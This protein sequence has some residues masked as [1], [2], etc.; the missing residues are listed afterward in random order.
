VW[1]RGVWHQW[2]VAC[3]CGE[4]SQHGVIGV[5]CGRQRAAACNGVMTSA[6]MARGGMWHQR[7]ACGQHQ[8]RVACGRCGN[9]AVMAYWR[10]GMAYVA[11][12]HGS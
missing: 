2:H 10:N 3:N 4:I 1:Q 11:C 9:V 6:V 7:L 8:Q 5:S 12:N